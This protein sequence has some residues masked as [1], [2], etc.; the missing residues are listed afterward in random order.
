MCGYTSIFKL[1]LYLKLIIYKTTDAIEL[2]CFKFVSVGKRKTDENE[3]IK[4]GVDRGQI[5]G[6]AIFSTEATI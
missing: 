3:Q 5:Y 1:I 6:D 2:Q 4:V